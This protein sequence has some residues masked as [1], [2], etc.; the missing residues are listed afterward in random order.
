MLNLRDLGGWPT[1]GGGRVRR[2]QVYRSAA[3]ERLAE[4]DWPAFAALGIRAVYDLRTE[5][6]R[7]EWPD[8]LPPGVTSVPVDVF[9]G[10]V[11]PATGEPRRGGE[12]DGV[13]ALLGGATG[14]SVFERG[15][16]AL[17]HLPSARAA[18]GRL[19]AGL[20][21]D[22]GRPALM[23][24][25]V[26]KDRTGWA[27]AALL[28]FL[29]VPDDLVTEEFLTSNRDLFAGGRQLEGFRV[30]GGDPERP[31]PLV[32]LR[33]AVPARRR[34]ADARGV[35]ERRRL[36]RR[37]PGPG[38][39]GPRFA[40]P[41]PRRAGLSAVKGS[42]GA[43]TRPRERVAPSARHMRLAR[44]LAACVRD[45]GVAAT[46]RDLPRLLLAPLFLRR[47]RRRKL[48]ELSAD[49]FDAAHGT[50]TAAVLVGRELGPCVTRGGHLVVHYE[51]TS[52][53]PSA[54]RS[55]SSPA[56]SISPPAPSSTS[57]A[58]RASRSWWPPRT[59]SAGSSAW[60]SRRPASRSPG[61][62]SRATGRGRSTR[63]AWSCVT[64]DAEDYAFP[65]GPL[66]VYLF[67][68]FPGAVL[69]RVVARLEASLRE[70][71]V[72]RPS[73]T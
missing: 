54:C 42:R 71:R 69:E 24:C 59:P 52:E 44:V 18:Y 41:R 2:G 62:T 37:G 8:R 31:A 34:R 32:F 67:N 10:A 57:A 23:H 29:G 33:P 11:H 6:E 56:A 26:G 66:V 3:L 28:L 19:F 9:A 43:W 21:R 47:L 13:S 5:A 64:M 55:T 48:A 40:A 27:A 50:D 49:G 16:R 60:T 35:R 39:R 36:R 25:A 61:A 51:T 14:A 53:A 20:A 17:V 7:V 68:P 15:Y 70:C 4:E 22:G 45:L 72:R 1:A 73:S 12:V 63:H 38:R 30:P 58:A 65:A 46:V